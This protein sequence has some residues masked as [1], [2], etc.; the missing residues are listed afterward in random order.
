MQIIYYDL[1]LDFM[2]NRT[3]Q[4]IKVK[5]FEYLSRVIRLNLYDN[6][7]PVNFNGWEQAW[8][9]ANI[10]GTTVTAYAEKCTVIGGSNIIEVKLSESLTTL[11]GE[12]HCEVKIFDGNSFILYTATF[13]LDVEPSV[14][15]SE[16]PETLA[17]TELAAVLKDHEN[18]I[19]KLENNSGG[20]RTTIG[21]AYRV[22][23]GVTTSKIGAIEPYIPETE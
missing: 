5:Q 12:E 4:T 10:N 20:G 16:S 9:Y 3:L 22:S 15:T 14:A 18:R 6:G 1:H 19:T 21:T 2:E 23:G 17:T 8:L 13:N 7:Q 11:S